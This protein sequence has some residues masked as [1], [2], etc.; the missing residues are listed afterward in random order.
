MDRSL[1]KE[2]RHE[3][4]N[5]RIATTSRWLSA[6]N[7][8]QRE[9]RCNRRSGQRHATGMAIG[10]G[11]PWHSAAIYT[12]GWFAGCVAKLSTPTSRRSYWP[13]LSQEARDRPVTLPIWDIA[14]Q[15]E[16]K[17][18][19]RMLAYANSVADADWR[20]AISQTG[21][22]ERRHKVVLSNLVHALAPEPACVEPRDTEWAYLVT[23]FGECIDS[24][25]AFGLF[26]L[27][28]RSLLCPSELVDTFEPVI[29]EESRHIL[30]FAN[31]VA[32]HRRAMP[33]S[34]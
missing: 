32:W 19:L 10:S 15:T 28:R 12:S 1:W 13:K 8:K 16:G 21:W 4:Y 20:D 25:F 31:W 23:G 17:A 11:A 6:G 2:A 26:E 7:P 3:R 30:L 34:V 24:F 14:V 29:Q 27:A 33:D 5:R 9:S 18:R 22:E